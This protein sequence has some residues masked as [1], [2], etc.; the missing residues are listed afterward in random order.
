MPTFT[1]LDFLARE[2]PELNVGPGD[3]HTQNA[4]K[5]NAYIADAQYIKDWPD[6]E[7]CEYQY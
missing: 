5:R 2:M 6:F 4:A 1:P 3:T 7:V